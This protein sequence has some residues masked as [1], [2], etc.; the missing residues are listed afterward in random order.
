MN[1]FKKLIDEGYVDPK[2]K[3]IYI[4]KVLN[5]E[6]FSYVQQVWSTRKVKRKYF[7]HLL[8]LLGKTIEI[9][10]VPYKIIG[11]METKGIIYLTDGV[12]II[13]VDVTELR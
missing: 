2:R 3:V 6:E 8:Y 13:E 7:K 10:G 5:P 1:P 12:R 11:V 9:D 4:D